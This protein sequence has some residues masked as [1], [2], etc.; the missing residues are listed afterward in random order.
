M[1]YGDTAVK[2]KLTLGIVVY[3]ELLNIYIKLISN[4]SSDSVTYK[5]LQTTIFQNHNLKC[6]KLRRI[7][8]QF[9]S[10]TF[11]CEFF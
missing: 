1:S 7:G 4:H 3:I 11:G 9:F 10:K 2:F 5:I 8:F 6:T